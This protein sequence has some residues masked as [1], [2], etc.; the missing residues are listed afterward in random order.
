MG[1]FNFLQSNLWSE[2]QNHLL[3]PKILFSVKSMI[4]FFVNKTS[5]LLK[6]ADAIIS[7]NLI[8]LDDPRNTEPLAAHYHCSKLRYN[9]RHFN[10]NLVHKYTQDSSEIEQSRT[11]FC[12]IIRA[13]SKRIK[14]FRCSTTIQRKRV[15]VQGAHTK[16]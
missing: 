14:S 12:V 4:L 7:E 2:R 16:Y 6:I 10:I 8:Q 3:K 5:S 9:L 11:F 13:K 1:N 15:C